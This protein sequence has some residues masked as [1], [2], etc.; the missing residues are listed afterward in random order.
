MAVN[1]CVRPFATLGLAGVTATDTR[2]AAVT[3]NAALPLTPPLVAEIVLL[4][5]AVVIARPFEPA[6]LLTV[7]ADGLD[8]D[9]V[10]CAVRSCVELSEN[11]P[12]AVNWRDKPFAILGVA[13]VTPIDTSAAAVTLKLVLPLTPPLVA[14][15]VLLPTAVV[16]ARP[17][18]PAA[19][20]TVATAPSEDAQV[21][22]VVRS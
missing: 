2:V 16:V 17:F 19:L 4:P 7:A 12:V 5:T 10:T 14:E 3:V 21:T 1:C 18:E 15:I 6:A 8:D 20:L 11:T 22:A 9:H 13:G